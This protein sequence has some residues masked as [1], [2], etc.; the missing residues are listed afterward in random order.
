MFFWTSSVH[1]QVT[2]HASS[3]E[4]V[5]LDEILSRV[6]TAHPSLD[7]AQ[8]RADA[9]ALRADQ[10][11]LWP[12][13]EVGVTI[14]PMPVFTAKGAQRSQWRVSQQIPYRGQRDAQVDYAEAVADEAE[15]EVEIRRAD[16]LLMAKEAY[17][18]LLLA[19]I[20]IADLR[21]F[22]AEVTQF[23]QAAT[24]QYEVGQ[25]TQQAILMA[26]IEHNRLSQRMLEQERRAE[27]ARLLLARLLNSPD[28]VIE[29][30]E[31][32]PLPILGGLEAEPLVAIA[33][34]Q[35]SEWQQFEQAEAQAMLRE[36][37][38]DY[39]AKPT[40]DAH[41]SYV[42][43]VNSNFPA[44]ATGRDALAVGVSV[45]LSLQRGR[46]SASRQE[47]RVQQRHVEVEREVF[48]LEVATEVALHLSELRLA[49]QQI[50]L[51]EEALVPQAH[52][53][54]EATLTA[55]T[56]GTI[57]FINLLDARRTLLRLHMDHHDTLI[58]YLKAVAALERTLGVNRL[59]DVLPLTFRPLMEP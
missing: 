38:V 9:L 4:A 7:A 34:A 52:T 19:Q 8:L 43:I 35:R 33:M 58:A 37:L 21:A 51:Y 22:A 56:A 24:A 39:E 48:A 31:M 50:D 59:T 47:A 20:H 10:V 46:L 14:M 53:T 16:L 11:S 49:Q 2:H 54:V 41:V 12:D 3:A 57:D 1:A 55:Y 15:A 27:R 29:H 44:A 28:E 23:E 36:R 30:A 5:S 17:Y 42:D 45:G 18:R 25:G 6:A 13:P 32:A 26:Q 40:L